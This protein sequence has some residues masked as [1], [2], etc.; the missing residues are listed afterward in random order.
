[1]LV[2]PCFTA[3]IAP[4]AKLVLRRGTLMFPAALLANAAV[5]MAWLYLS[6]DGSLDENPWLYLLFSAVT[7]LL[8]VGALI[9]QPESSSDPAWER[10][11]EGF[12]RMLPLIAVSGAAVS[13]GVT[14][15]LSNVSHAVAIAIYVSAAI[16]LVLA[17]ARQSLLLLERDRLIEAEKHA[18]E[19]EHKFQTLFHTE[20]DG[21]ALLD[22]F[23]GFLEVNPACT[24][25]FG[26]RREEL[27]NMNMVDLE[28]GHGT[29]IENLVALTKSEGEGLLDVQCGTQDGRVLDVEISSGLL[30]GSDELFVTFRDVSERKKSEETRAQLE[31]QLRQSQ[32]LEAIGTLASGIA[33]DFNNILSAILGN[34]ELALHETDPASASVT[35]LNEIRKAGQ[36]A[37]ELIRRIVAFARPQDVNVRPQRLASVIEEAVQLVRVTLSSTANI[38][39]DLKTDATAMID[40]TQVSQ[41]LFNLCTNAYQAMPHHSGS[42]HVTLDICEVAGHESMQGTELAPGRYVC[43]HVS[44]TGSGIDPQIVHRIFEPFFTTKLSGGGSGL[45]LSVV[46]GIVRA[47]GGAITVES[48]LGRGATFRLYFPQANESPQFEAVT[49]PLA[50]ARSRGANQHI[51]YV[52]DEEPLVFL[53]QRLLEKH[54]YR[55]SGFTDADAALDAFLQNGA[56]FDLVIT[57]K[58][59]PGRSA[60]S[61]LEKCCLHDRARALCWSPVICAP[62]KSKRRK[63][64]AFRKSS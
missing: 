25:L 51:L 42:I 41:V 56:Q 23:G 22:T 52:D 47:H 36:R 11:C 28:H 46:H 55:V 12:L 40:S 7:L 34:A 39:C 64:S 35:S 24:Q 3:A 19:V 63:Q 54:G 5:W 48:E 10:Q 17:F 4:T 59:M 18:H 44:D 57:D 21:L 49:S 31:A 50:M 14:W 37:K 53:T 8:G 2:P 15:W 33:H 1:M 29:R 61:W 45:G 62:M 43:L 30:S 13:I 38:T 9:W 6:Q 26:F 32:K 20:R 60:P 16:T 27:L 58:S